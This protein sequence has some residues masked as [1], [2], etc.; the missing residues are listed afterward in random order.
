M[1]IRLIAFYFLFA[2]KS[3]TD[4]VIL[5]LS[6]LLDDCSPIM[7]KQQDTELPPHP[8]IIK[9]ESHFEVIA[10]GTVVGESDTLLEILNLYFCSFY[11]FNMEYPKSN[12]N[13]LCYM[14]KYIFEQNISFKMPAKVLSIHKKIMT[15]LI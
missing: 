9:Q 13:F 11:A 6:H 2:G 15:T 10:E 8:V 5:A 14:H 1:L 12:K 4:C 3:E 7:K